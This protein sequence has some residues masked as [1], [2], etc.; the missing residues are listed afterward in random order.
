M[1]DQITIDDFGKLEIR[2]GTVVEASVPEGSKKLIRQVVD[3]GEEVGKRVIFS[4]ILEWYQPEDLVGK[5]MPY[6]VN[7]EPRKMPAFGKPSEGKMGEESQGMLVAAGGER[8][9]LV[10]P[11]GE[12]EPGTEVS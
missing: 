9:V 1:K 5:Q 2:I 11:V 6:V 12:V 4:G 3:F 7:L 8:A 10:C